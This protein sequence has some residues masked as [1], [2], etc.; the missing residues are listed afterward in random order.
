MASEQKHEE[1][2]QEHFKNITPNQVAVEARLQPETDVKIAKILTISCDSEILAYEALAGEVRYNG[3]ANFKVLF[4]DSDGA[5]N[6]MDYNAD[7]SDKVVDEAIMPSSECL[8]DANT[9]DTDTVSVTQAEIR[10]SA[11]VEINCKVAVSEHYNLIKESSE[12]IYTQTDELEYDVISAKGG[13]TFYV[14]EEFEPKDNIVNILLCEATNI[15]VDVSAGLDCVVC[16]GIIDLNVI[17]TT[18]NGIIK[19]ENFATEY[20]HEINASGARIDDKVVYIIK[21]NS[22]TVTLTDDLSSNHKII[23]GDFKMQAECRTV[24]LTKAVAIIDAFSVSKEI[25]I[26]GESIDFK[27]FAGSKRFDEMIEGTAN[28][29]DDLPSVDKVICLTSS[30]VQ[31]ANI[32]NEG[33]KLTIEGVLHTGIIYWNNEYETRNS[34]SVELPYSLTVKCDLPEGTLEFDGNACIVKITARPKKSGEVEL[35][36]NVKFCVN[37]YCKKVGYYIKDIEIGEFKVTH[38]SAIAV[39]ITRQGEKLWD[40]AK[41]LHTTPQNILANNPDLKEPLPSGERILI[42]RQ[43]SADI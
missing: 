1:I 26:T 17:Y 15:T 19:N 29:G 28:L 35:S 22:F 32:Y 18:E 43:I 31:V 7:F 10:I 12:D 27:K 8:I 20:S 42:Y 30:K 40:V 39:Y 6:S 33:D 37:V 34:V 14:S 11:A 2:I 41:A 23:K 4:V 25:K 9:L 36:A 16:N 13:E 38:E 24:A 5:T 3:R 21:I